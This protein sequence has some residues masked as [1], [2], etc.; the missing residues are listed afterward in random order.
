MEGLYASLLLVVHCLNI[1]KGYC[2]GLFRVRQLEQFG[3][4]KLV[5]VFFHLPNISIATPIKGRDFRQNTLFSEWDL[6]SF[7]VHDFVVVHRFVHFV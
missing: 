5:F 4:V 1:F 6:Y 3:V 2:V 7:L